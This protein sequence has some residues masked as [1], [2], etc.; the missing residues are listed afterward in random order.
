M[1]GHRIMG[2]GAETC[3]LTKRC[4]SRDGRHCGNCRNTGEAH[5]LLMMDKILLIQSHGNLLGYSSRLPLG[6]RLHLCTPS[7]DICN[8]SNDNDDDKYRCLLNDN[9]NSRFLAI[10][11]G[12]TLQNLLLRI[13]GRQGRSQLCLGLLA[14]RPVLAVWNRKGKP[15]R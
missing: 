5:F 14:N 9:K 8:N 3:P 4:N 2:V 13:D 1:D 11:P 6:A 10:S 12:L 15:A 7:F